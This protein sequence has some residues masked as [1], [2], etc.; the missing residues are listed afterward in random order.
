MHFISVCLLTKGVG[1]C[2]ISMGGQL[3]ESI[4]GCCGGSRVNGRGVTER[5]NY[6]WKPIVI[7]RGAGEWRVDVT[8]RGIS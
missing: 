5:K 6:M 1:D 2:V 7:C 4:G 3:K 8:F